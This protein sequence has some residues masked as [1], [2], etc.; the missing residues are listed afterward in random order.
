MCRRH[1][2]GCSVTIDD[3]VNALPPTGY[4]Q[5]SSSE[6]ESDPNPSPSSAQSPAASCSEHMRDLQNMLDDMDDQPSTM[7][8]GLED[9]YVHIYNGTINVRSKNNSKIK[10]LHPFAVFGI[11]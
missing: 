10:I 3:V 8:L 2:V 7:W 11:T 5:V 6:D 1:L 4:P 9:G